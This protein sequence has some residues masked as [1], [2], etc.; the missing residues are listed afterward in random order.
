LQDPPL[1]WDIIAMDNIK[2]NTRHTLKNILV[3]DYVIAFLAFFGFLAAFHALTPTLP[4]YLERLGSSKR[5]IGVL[6]GTIGISALVARL[7][8]GR[9]LRTY[10][11]K[12][13]MMGA[14]VLFGLSFLSLVIFRPFWPFLFVRLLQGIA[15][16]S[17]DTA[18]IAY[19]VRI[20][21]FAYRAQA[22]SFF[23][24]G[25][26]LASAVAATSGVYILN[27]YGF[28]ILVLACTGLCVC[29]FLFSWR[30]KGQRA[31]EPVSTPAQNTLFFQPKILAPAI[32][33]FLF[34]VSMTGVNAFFP[35]YALRCG[36]TN[37]G[38]FFSSTAVTLIAV[39]LFGGFVFEIYSKEK[40]IFTFLVLASVA[41]VVLSFSRT[42]PMFILVGVLW[43][44]AAGY[45][46]PVCM[47]YALEY[48]GSSDGTSIGTYQAFMD[49]GLAIGPVTMGIIVQLT[50][51]R[52]MFLCAAF[53]CLVNL[54]Y[55]RFYLR[56]KGRAAHG[57]GA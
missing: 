21:P 40:V 6:V 12:V 20:I 51:Y 8:V 31:A 35:L 55:F 19:V 36:V 17:L 9:I 25:P 29:S 38:I 23:F 54:G 47:A 41:I 57:Y 4:I 53:V 32:M 37:P 11:E 3:R 27:A 52:S 42:L 39:R 1:I 44:I 5:E 30:L 2:T 33:S 14:T 26:S 22:I 48:A 43:G 18:I 15:F 10:S 50:S 24:I 46:I 16:A 49:I 56:K 13:V 34:Y 45:L 7:L 28:S